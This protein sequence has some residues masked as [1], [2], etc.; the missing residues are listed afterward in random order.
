MNKSYDIYKGA[1]RM[2]WVRPS[3]IRVIVERAAELRA[4]GR[5]VL[6]LSNGEPDFD[7]PTDIK[8]ETIK[9]IRANETHYASNRGTPELRKVLSETIKKETGLTYDPAT[10]ILVTTSGAEALNNAIMALIEE[11]DE[12]I[13]PTPA[14]MNCK[15]LVQM[16]GGKFVD[17]Q[18]KQ[19]ND[20]DIDLEELESLITS[21][22]KMLV[23]NNPS[24]PTGKVY[25]KETLEGICRLAIKYNLIVLADEMYSRLTYT[26]PFYSIATFPGMQERSIVVSG[27]SKTYAMTGWRLGYIAADARFISLFV[28]VH[29][30][31]TTC[32][33]TF[34]QSGAA[35]GM[36]TERTAQEVAASINA[37]ARRRELLMRCIGEIEGLSYVEPQGA[38]YL[39]VNVS[40]TGLTGQEFAVR[41]LEE[42]YVATVPAIG[43]GDGCG[44][45][46]RISYAT[47]EANIEEAAGRIK[48]FVAGLIH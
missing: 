4:E 36:V 43:L 14:F 46:I 15:T 24:N 28:R 41:L 26:A 10:E 2:E 21:K 33:P 48:E 39:M 5:P 27:F 34:I 1:A 17:M 29:Q 44:D 42:K 6:S 11:G 3:P 20:F 8:E 35:R 30:Y 32:T 38:F 13:I 31:C 47:S 23:I 40:K 37:F 22:T 45:F 16:C 19:E 18:L 12:V 25:S 7:T 9:A